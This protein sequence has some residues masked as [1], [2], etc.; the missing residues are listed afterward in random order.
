MRRPLMYIAGV[1]SALLIG[2]GCLFLVGL[3][4]AHTAR[5][6]VSFAGVKR[7][8]I[9]SGGGS[10]TLTGSAETTEAT[11][12]RTVR[13]DFRK[14][15]FSERV[16]A[17]G[18]LVLRN[19]CPALF[20]VVCSVNYKLTVPEGVEVI[21]S[22]S[23]GSITVTGLDGSVDVSSSGGSLRADRTSGS[24]RLRSSGGGIAVN[25]ATSDRVV[26]DSSGGGVSLSF[27][28]EPTMVDASS[29][30]GGVSV[31][32]PKTSAEYAVDASSSGGG[33]SVK[34]ATRSGSDRRIR[35][36]SSGGGVSVRYP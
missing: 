22:S 26:V 13:S 6:P 25:E 17:D 15:T 28:D 35:V 4:T 31:I 9:R 5:T 24:L 23:G 21:G 20:S 10:V 36:R 1:V 32:I 33:T 18:T 12:T 29:S 34:V 3:I 8:E 27:A 11:G 2:S 19:S 7:V 30:G 14:P 16:A